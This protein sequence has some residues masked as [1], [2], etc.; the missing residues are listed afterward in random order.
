MADLLDAFKANLRRTR[1]I[2]AL[3]DA[4]AGPSSPSMER[5]PGGKGQVG[6]PTAAAAGRR[7]RLLREMARLTAQRE[8][9]ELAVASLPPLEVMTFQ[10]VYIRG[11]PRTAAARKLRQK[12]ASIA[13]A[14][15]RLQDTIAQVLDEG[16]HDHPQ[17]RAQ[18]AQ[19]HAGTS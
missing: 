6:D 17:N 9:V 3:L 2:Q 19:C 16:C 10:L 14:F 7:E 15:T 4:A 11:L 18:S 12:P 5:P 8:T 1:E 13:A